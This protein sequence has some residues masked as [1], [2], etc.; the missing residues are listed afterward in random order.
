MPTSNLKLSLIDQISLKLICK[1][2]APTI[3]NKK[4]KAKTITLQINK[5][6]GLPLFEEHLTTKWQW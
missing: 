6:K 4:N 1:A 5:E 2:P 3:K